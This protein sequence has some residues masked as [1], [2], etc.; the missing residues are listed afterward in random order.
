VSHRAAIFQLRG[1]VGP[2][3]KPMSY[4]KI[5]LA[6]GVSKS[7]VEKE[8]KRPGNLPITD[9]GGAPAEPYT[10]PLSAG[11][12][13]E[14]AS[15]Q[16]AFNQERVELARLRLRAD[17][18]EQERRMQLLENPGQ[19]GNAT[20][21][22][23]FEG[24]MRQL[25]DEITRLSSRQPSAPAAAALPAHQPSFVDQLTQFRQV[26]ETM[27]SFA[28]PSA[29][30]SA[31]EL[32][33][34]V[35]MERLNMEERE[36]TQRLTMEQ[37]EREDRAAGERLRNDAIARL[38]EQTGPL[39]AGALQK[40]ISDQPGNGAAPAAATAPLVLP[41]P[42]GGVMPAHGVVTGPCPQCGAALRFHPEP[43]QDDRCPRCQLLL[44]VVDGEIQPKLASE[45]KR[46]YAS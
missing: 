34:K 23:L 5:A 9:D 1:Q 12:D 44:A 38:I 45:K 21:M 8:L 11:A 32:E 46:T 27:Q 39:L 33:F 28:P 18:L 3:G 14:L 6:L 37:R 25:R 22:M 19:A 30:S 2:D 42:G 36:R 15:A 31:V 20:L 16:R 43:G 35:A 29:P 40:W 4:G 26:S 24:Q 13:P 10:P 17:R 7:L 41:T